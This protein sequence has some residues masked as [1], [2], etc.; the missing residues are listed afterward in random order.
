MPTVVYIGN[1]LRELRKQQFL[2]QHMLAARSGVSQV[3]IARIERNRAEPH[4]STIHKL[5][6]ALGVSPEKFV[7]KEGGDT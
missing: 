3:A 5:A 7:K 1:R 2:T 4:F 6:D